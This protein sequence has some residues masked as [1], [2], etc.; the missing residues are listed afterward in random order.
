MRQPVEVFRVEVWRDGVLLEG[1]T[2]PNLHAAQVFAGHQ[3]TR[4]DTYR[5]LVM[6]PRAETP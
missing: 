6:Y 1:R 3:R 5:A 4:G 2:F